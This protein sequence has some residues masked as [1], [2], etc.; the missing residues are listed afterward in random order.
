MISLSRQEAAHMRAQIARANVTSRSEKEQLIALRGELALYAEIAPPTCIM[1]ELQAV[2]DKAASSPKPSLV[3]PTH[4]QKV[5]ELATC[6]LGVAGTLLGFAAVAREVGGNIII[7]GTGLAVVHFS[8]RMAIAS[9]QRFARLR[10]DEALLARL[11]GRNNIVVPT[12]RERERARKLIILA[13]EKLISAPARSQGAVPISGSVMLTN[14]I[15]SQRN[16]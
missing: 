16:L 15:N 11:S 14:L 3:P 5:A 9:G 8:S 2:L 6:T 10:K 13:D 1:P 4:G 12:K 7:F